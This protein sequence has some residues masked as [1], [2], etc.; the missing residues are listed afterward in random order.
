MMT[1]SNSNTHVLVTGGSGFIA[2]HCILQLLAAGYTVKATVR[3]RSREAELR[4]IYRQA[5]ADTSAL[6]FVEADLQSDAG[7]SDAVA[8][9][10]YVL[11]VASPTPSIGTTDEEAFIRPAVEGVVRVLR[12]ARDAGVKRV[13][14]TS[15]FGAIGMG[16]QRTTPFTEND[17]SDLTKPVPP[18]QKSKTLAEKAAWEFIAK[19][20]RGMELSAVNPTGVLGPVLS[21]DYSHSIRAIHTM[22]NGEMAG[23]PKLSFSYADVRDV[24]DL[25]L[26]AMVSPA[27][28]GERFIA[29]NDGIMSMLDIATI[30]RARL[31]EAAA[32]APTRELHDWLI[33]LLALFNK[34][35]RMIVPLLGQ[36]KQA[37]SQKARK[38]LQ[39]KPRS[40][41]E[42]VVATAESLIRLGLVK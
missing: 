16:Q 37:S 41:E 30:L 12:V 14:L 9:C 10:T 35:S 23:C 6:T 26:K 21:A 7:W 27:A 18:Y 3:S 25:H 13:V 36:S 24:A 40:N 2:S 39:W 15:A 31:G 1:H 29:A 19:E 22:L 17:W 42:S 8:G 5:G 33:R 11:H 32:K 4:T 38:L 28:A 20:G 34:Q